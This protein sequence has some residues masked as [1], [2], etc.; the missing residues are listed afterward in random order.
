M[1]IPFHSS[2]V[3]RPREHPPPSPSTPA[4]TTKYT[5]VKRIELCQF[6]EHNLHHTKLK[7]ELSLPSREVKGISSRHKTRSN[8]NAS[9]ELTAS[10]SAT[11]HLFSPFSDGPNIETTINN[12]H[13]NH[14]EHHPFFP[15]R[16]A[17]PE[18]DTIIRQQLISTV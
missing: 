1:S 9:E 3:L 8:K 15:S 16:F 4:R 7:V 17:P 14:I 13:T 5:G 10:A 18:L 12:V 11:G 2:S 6:P